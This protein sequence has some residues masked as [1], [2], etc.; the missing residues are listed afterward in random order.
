MVRST[1][2]FEDKVFRTIERLLRNS[3]RESWN[4]VSVVDE[5]NHYCYK[6]VNGVIGTVRRDYVHERIA[7]GVY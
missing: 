6:T 5:A 2:S 3:G 7:D 4:V 1:L